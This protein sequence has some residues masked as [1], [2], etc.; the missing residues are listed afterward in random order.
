MM[1][2]AITQAIAS[3]RVPQTVAGDYLMQSRDHRAIVALLFITSLAFIIVG[4]RCS[5]RIFFL[6]MF[7]LDDAL[8]VLSLCVCHSFIAHCG[9]TNQ[10]IRTF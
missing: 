6:E 4:A 3:G 10:S 9:Q 2:P 1:E 5:S 7:G 8:A